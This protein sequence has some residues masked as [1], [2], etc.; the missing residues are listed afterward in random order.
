M[1]NT[2]E[3]P[4][5]NKTELSYDLAIPLL[6]IYLKKCKSGYNTGTCIPM[7]HYSE[8]LNYGNGQDAPQLKYESR[9]FGI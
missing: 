5:K 6:G 9:K 2:M 4:Q 7:K 3:V 8:Q 1:E